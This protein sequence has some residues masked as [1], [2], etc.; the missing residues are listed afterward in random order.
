MNYEAA[1]YFVFTANSE[2]FGIAPLEQR[3]LGVN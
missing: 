1:D 2:P 3:L